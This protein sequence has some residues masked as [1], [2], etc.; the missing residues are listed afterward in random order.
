VPA[1]L[2]LFPLGT[3]LFPGSP[4]PLHVFEPRYRELVQ[5]LMRQPEPREFGVVAIREGHEVGAH[6]V[7]T[8]Y[9]V[10]CVASLD[11]IQQFPDGRFAV[12]AMG[13]RRF[14]LLRLD[15]SATYPGGEVELIDEPAVDPDDV[16][17]RIRRTR[18]AFAEYRRR[19]A[20]GEDLDLPTDPTALSYAVAAGLSVDLPER[21][22]LLE[23]PDAATRLADAAVILGREL[24]VMRALH[25]V[26]LQG[27]ALP[28]PRVN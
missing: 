16:D 3:V 14:R 17:D 8:L 1:R 26:P 18:A 22:R 9:G 27:T 28:P 20:S 25:A 11:E 12:L 4:L 24:A 2:P 21:Q 7:R 23:A 19:I 5:D 10:G 13:H 6:A 15:A